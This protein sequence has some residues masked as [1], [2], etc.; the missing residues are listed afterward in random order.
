VYDSPRLISINTINSGYGYN[1]LTMG[2][3]TCTL[4]VNVNININIAV[5][6]LALANAAAVVLIEV[7]SSTSPAANAYLPMESGIPPE[8][9]ERDLT[10]LGVSKRREQMAVA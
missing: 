1:Q 2:V 8:D 9:P 7:G 10:T 6:A 3:T 4:N 5:N